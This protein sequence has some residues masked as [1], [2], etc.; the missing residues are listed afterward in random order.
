MRDGEMKSLISLLA[1]Y[2]KPVRRPNVTHFGTT[3]F[4]QKTETNPR[5]WPKFLTP[6]FSKA[7]TLTQSKHANA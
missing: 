4:A 7:T 6:A 3:D 5:S 2:Q 1:S